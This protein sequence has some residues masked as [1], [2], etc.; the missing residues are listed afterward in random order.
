MSGMDQVLVQE[1]IEGEKS[2]L[3]LPFAMYMRKVRGEYN[4]RQVDGL[5]LAG[6][7]LHQLGHFFHQLHQTRKLNGE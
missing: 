6:I 4:H 5:T 7:E 2:L 3:D 1:L